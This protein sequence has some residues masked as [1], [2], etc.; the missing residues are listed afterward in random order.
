MGNWDGTRFPPRRTNATSDDVVAQLGL[1]KPR[2]TPIDAQPA[3]ENRPARRVTTM[4]KSTPRIRLD[5]APKKAPAHISTDHPLATIRK[6]PLAA[7]L[8]VSAW[9]IDRWRKS[10]I[11]QVPLPIQISDHVL[12]WRIHDIELWLMQR[13]LGGTTGTTRERARIEA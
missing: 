13:Q 5:K 3:G 12:V 2:V 7:F 6:K 9:T 8:G 11:N 10:G 4:T 1:S